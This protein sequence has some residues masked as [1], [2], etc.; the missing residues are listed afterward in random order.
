VNPKARCRRSTTTRGR[1]PTLTRSCLSWPRDRNSCPPI[2]PGHPA[3]TLVMADFHRTGLGPYSGQVCALQDRR[4]APGIRP[5]RYLYEATIAHKAATSLAKSTSMSGDTYKTNHRRHAFWGGHGCAVRTR[6]RRLSKYPNVS[7]DVKRLVHEIAPAR[8]HRLA[9][10][11]R[12]TFT[13]RPRMTTRPGT[14]F[15]ATSIPGGPRNPGK[16]IATAK[17]RPRAAPFSL[18]ASVS[19][20]QNRLDLD[21]PARPISR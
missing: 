20:R 5:Y 15:S 8:Q 3:G 16:E 19:S 13:F 4:R 12:T 9:S 21:Q 18:H 2:R 11:R 10:A 1:V 17:R 7:Q 6:R 14:S